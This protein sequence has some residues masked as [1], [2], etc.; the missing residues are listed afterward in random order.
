M[1]DLQ[2]SPPES[3]EGVAS[4]LGPKKWENLGSQKDSITSNKQKTSWLKNT[5]QAE[6]SLKGDS[7]DTHTSKHTS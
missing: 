3:L 6:S 7:E 4:A 1:Q 5:V 2:T